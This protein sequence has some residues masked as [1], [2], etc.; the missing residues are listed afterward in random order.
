VVVVRG[1]TLHVLG[2]STID[3]LTF[4]E[5]PEYSCEQ[6]TLGDD[7]W[8]D[9]NAMPEEDIQIAEWVGSM[10]VGCACIRQDSLVFASKSCA[11]GAEYDY[12]IVRV[13]DRD[14]GRWHSTVVKMADIFSA[15]PPRRPAALR[16]PHRHM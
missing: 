13:H 3:I 10:D 16:A 8:T 14:A 12:V 9:F 2:G 7:A 4:E 6:F 11:H 1:Q 15:G 5:N